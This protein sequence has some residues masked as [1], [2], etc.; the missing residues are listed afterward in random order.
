MSTP[1]CKT[2]V[3]GFDEILNGGL[4]R[5]RLYLLQGSPGVGKTTLALQ[6]LLEGLRENEG[7][8]YITLSETHEELREVADSHG[9]N[10]SRLKI[11]EL[12]AL[13][14]KLRG[15]SDTT[16]FNPS[17]VELSRTTQALI[18][19]VESANPSRVVFDSLSELRMLSETPLRYRRQILYLKQY[20]AGRRCTVMMLD[21]HAAQEKDAQVESLAHGVFLLSKTSPEYGVARRQLTVEKVRGVKFREGNHDVLL[22]T[23]GL[24]I[25]PRLVASEHHSVFKSEAIASGIPAFD[26]LVG[27]GLHRGT[28][29][30]LM[31]PPGTGKSTLAARIALTAADRGEKSLF[32]TFDETRGTLRGR[33]VAL[34]MNILE[35]EESGL[36]KLV[37]VDPAEISPGDMAFRI[38]HAV[39]H[40]QV[41]L[42]VIDSINGYLN[43]MAEERY[44]SLQLHEL[45]SYLNQQGVTTLLILS[46]HGIIGSMRNP[47]DLTYLSDTVILLRYF[48]ALGDVRQA[49]SVIKKRSGDH[50][51]TIREM[52]ITAKGIEIG[53][54]LSQLRGVLTGIPVPQAERAQ[55]EGMG[56]A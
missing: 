3:E 25:F 5:N 49:I 29:N 33:S 47:I 20:F 42:V 16:F 17:E 15:E 28:S 38:K 14:E 32:F 45:L 48:E 24:V 18:D 26:T 23:G 44:L 55:A 50:E 27:G 8:L 30:M 46:Q 37:Q 13:E 51:R 4:P 12:S 34:G 19:A 22:L 11:F 10:L 31:G 1:R 6:F 43:S 53:D 7:G 52:K 56:F 35:H 21:D 54:P 39:T 40:D 41:R 2:G 36:F 9:W